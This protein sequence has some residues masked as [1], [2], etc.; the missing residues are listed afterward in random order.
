MVI[1]WLWNFLATG[2]IPLKIGSCGWLTRGT[3]EWLLTDLEW[4][5]DTCFRFVGEGRVMGSTVKETGSPRRY[6]GKKEKL[7]S[8]S[9]NYKR[10]FPEYVCPGFLIFTRYLSYIHQIPTNERI[11]HTTFAPDKASWN[12]RS[13]IKYPRKTSHDTLSITPSNW[14]ITLR[15]DWVNNLKTHFCEYLARVWIFSTIFF[16]FFFVK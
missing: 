16:F 7:K 14:L 9:A 2:T 6:F 12:P 1:D 11:N 15:R 10:S 3:V 4:G 8:P 13:R 5:K